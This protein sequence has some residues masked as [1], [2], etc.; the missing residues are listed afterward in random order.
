MLLLLLMVL[1]LVFVTMVMVLWLLLL[2]NNDN[3][4]TRKKV[5]LKIIKV[6][7]DVSSFICRIRVCHIIE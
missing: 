6:N 4:K 7:S 1:L 5:V 2:C 3:I